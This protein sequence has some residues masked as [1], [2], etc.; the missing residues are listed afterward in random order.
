MTEAVFGVEG[1]VFFPGPHAVG[2]WGAD[3]MN[4]RIVGGVL[5]HCLEDRH[6][7]PD[8]LP[9]RLTVDLLRPL[10]MKQFTVR[11]SL[12]REGRRIK[13]ADAEIV[14]DGTVGAR[15]SL[16]FLRRAPQPPGHVWRPDDPMRA[17]L[18]PAEP[19][20]NG[21]ALFLWPH[22]HGEVDPDNRMAVWEGGARNS[23]WI[24]ERIPLVQGAPL[25]PFVRAALAGDVTS[26]LTG[27]GSA[28][29][30]YINADY[31][32]A[33]TRLPEGEDIGLQAVSHLSADGVAT[34]TVTVY[35]GN[36]PIGTCTIVALA[37]TAAAFYTPRPTDSDLTA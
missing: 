8:L 6:G 21:H 1:D 14:Q 10:G 24:R 19:E 16:V 3:M 5:A 37:N 33:L 2:P 22:G 28:G 23:A 12:V 26:P 30:Q 17:P 13:I 36:G 15:A 7:D 27:W 11:T 34:G 9:A 18:P 32:L 4:G 20:N 25:T 35:D 31:T 29:L